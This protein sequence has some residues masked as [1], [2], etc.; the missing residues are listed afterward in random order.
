MFVPKLYKS[1]DVHV[2]REIISENSFALLISSVD[3]IRA[4]HSMMMMNENDPE[5]VYIETHISRA[6]PQAKILKNGDEV[7]CDFLGAHTYISS[8]WY[9]HINVSTWNYEAVQIYGKVELM[10]HEDLYIHLEKLT[11]KYENFQQC[12]MMVKDMGKEFVEKEMK[13]AFGIKIIPTEIFIKQKLSQNRK[14]NDFQNIISQLEHSDD[15]ARKIAEKM[16]LIKK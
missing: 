11:S 2:M 8:S 9:D 3:K 14:E 15:N 5:N 12:P 10:T 6:N 16:K 4:T 13:G 7:L 1:E